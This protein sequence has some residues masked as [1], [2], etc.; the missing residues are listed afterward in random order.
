MALS[1]SSQVPPSE[2]ESGVTL[3]TP[4]TRQPSP[5]GSPGMRGPVAEASRPSGSCAAAVIAANLRARPGARPAGIPSPSNSARTGP[6][7]G[8]HEH[9]RDVRVP[10]RRHNGKYLAWACTAPERTLQPPP[11][12]HEAK[13]PGDPADL[14]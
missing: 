12:P 13:F 8:M 1:G 14:D 5:A 10:Q 2:K 11:E 3:T 9:L 7:C 4:M 6:G